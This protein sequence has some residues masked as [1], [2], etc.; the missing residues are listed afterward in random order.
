MKGLIRF[1]RVDWW[2]TLQLPLL[3]WGALMGLGWA[4]YD[5]SLN[6][7]M[8]LGWLLPTFVLI[9][10]AF[11]LGTFLLFLKLHDGFDEAYEEFARRMPRLSGPRRSDGI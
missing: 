10:F 11:R 6:E 8:R 1:A 2:Q 4:N 5:W 9:W 7:I 3:L